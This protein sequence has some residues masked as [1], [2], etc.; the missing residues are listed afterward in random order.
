M[1]TYIVYIFIILMSINIIIALSR[2][3]KEKFT[4]NN[5]TEKFKSVVILGMARNIEGYLPT[6]ME[7]MENI[8]TLF[9]KGSIIIYEND[10]SDKTL[11]ILQNWKKARI[12]N[13]KNVQGERTHRLEHGRNILLEE[14]LKENSEYIIIL[15][16]DDKNMNITN[17]AILTSLNNEN[18]DWAVMGANQE[19]TYYDLWALRTFDNWMPGDI[20]HCGIDTNMSNSMW[21]NISK[22]ENLIEVKSCFGGLGIYKTK[23]L[24]GC[25]YDGKT[26]PKFNCSYD[27]SGV[28]TEKCEHVSLH[29]CIRNNGGKIFINPKMINS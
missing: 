10:S 29:E 5:N 1:N 9:E 16:M 27:T 4:D 17:E 2:S 19:G 15:D 25:K 24:N 28:S 14:A 23:Y 8:L 13:E 11:E 26:T 22:N 20:W 3:I 6:I 18:E 7:K 21:R 12:I